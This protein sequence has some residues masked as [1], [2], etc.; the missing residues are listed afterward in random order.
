MKTISLIISEYDNKNLDR[1]IRQYSSEQMI[2]VNDKWYIKNNDGLEEINFRIKILDFKSISK[3][4][5]LNWIEKIILKSIEKAKEATNNVEYPGDF[6]LVNENYQVI[7]RVESLL[8]RYQYQE[9][10]SIID[11]YIDL[12]LFILEAHLF[13]NGN[14]RFAFSLLR[15]LMVS[16]GFYLRWSNE[17][18]LKKHHLLMIQ[19]IKRLY[20]WISVC[21]I[22][23]HLMRL[24]QHMSKQMKVAKII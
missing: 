13:K 19:F 10:W 12:F 23:R 7:D 4:T 14:K 3:T 20:V 1:F 16:S 21:Q 8:L 9:N 11:Y 15:N 5:F 18:Y 22:D 6:I 17:T 2:Y 24:L